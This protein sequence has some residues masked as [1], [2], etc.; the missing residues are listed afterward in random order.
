MRPRT[1]FELLNAL[2]KLDETITEALEGV[3]ADFDVNTDISDADFNAIQR[4]ADFGVAS[5]AIYNL[6]AK[7]ITD[8][9]DSEVHSVALH[10][11]GFTSP[12]ISLLFPLCKEA[13]KW[14]PVT[15]TIQSLDP[16]IQS[17]MGTRKHALHSICTFVKDSNRRRKT[18]QVI[19]SRQG[20]LKKAHVS[21]AAPQV[22]QLRVALCELIDPDHS[23]VCSLHINNKGKHFMSPA[24][25]K[26][27]TV[28]LARSLLYLYGSPWIQ[29][30]FSLEKLF[31]CARDFASL[32]SQYPYLQCSIPVLCDSGDE[33]DFK[34]DIWEHQHVVAFGLRLL[35]IES[36]CMITPE[37]EDR[38]PEFDRVAPY[39]TLERVLRTLRRDGRVEDAYLKVAQSC[40]DFDDKLSSVQQPH[41]SPD[42]NYR[43]AIY[44]FIVNPLLEQLIQRFSEHSLDL[45]ETSNDIQDAPIRGASP[46]PRVA[47]KQNYNQGCNGDGCATQSL[48]NSGRCSEN[49]ASHHA[50]HLQEIHIADIVEKVS[51]QMTMAPCI[52]APTGPTVKPRV[53][54]TPTLAA[55]VSHDSGVIR[56]FDENAEMN[57]ESHRWA[58]HS[59]KFF[60][61]FD[62]F[63]RKHMKPVSKRNRVKIAILD[64]G[65]DEDQLGID[66]TRQAI[67]EE[68][69]ETTPG[70]KS[71]PIK[72]LR[73]FV[74]PSVLDTCG[75]GTHIV[76]ILMQLAPEVDF[77]IAKISDGLEVETVDQIAEVSLLF[78][79]SLP[80]YPFSPF[81]PS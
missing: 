12:G 11:C 22:P 40:L 32:C 16:G 30:S 38:D 46:L 6:L 64:T 79:F 61:L 20:A 76:E 17:H 77:Y 73:S 39:F 63:R 44:K 75:H 8:L 31:L 28:I 41:L 54:A 51:N 56:L 59:E 2:E 35:E 60:S 69:Q 37:E 57:G 36:G 67:K 47:G 23:D 27:L 58:Q 80:L 1:F 29:H 19:Y 18:A 13:E 5:T 68:R 33:F 78:L 48:Q 25:Q 52:P 81:L 62:S 43:L 42:K 34:E 9:C 49:H 55:L 21:S 71:D 66:I 45:L 50:V 10:L 26:R 74:G 53:R 7:Q 65:I 15:A 70:V 4:A 24:D 72:A 14:H 3:Y